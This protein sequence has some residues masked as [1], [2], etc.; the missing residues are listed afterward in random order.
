MNLLASELTA[1]AE[2]RKDYDDR[3]RQYGEHLE[4]INNE[5]RAL[6]AKPTD[7]AHVAQLKALMWEWEF[8]TSGIRR[9]KGIA[10]WMDSDLKGLGVT[11]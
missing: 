2:A 1:Y 5:I 10:D 11:K 4:S 7:P 3:L 9:L 6:P 8:A